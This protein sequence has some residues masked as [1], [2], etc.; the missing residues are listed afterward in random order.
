MIVIF[1]FHISLTMIGLWQG[2]IALE[3]LFY[4]QGIG[5]LFLRAVRFFDTPMVVATVVCFA[6]T[7]SQGIISWLRRKKTD[8]P[9][10]LGAHSTWEK[11]TLDEPGEISYSSTSRPKRESLWQRISPVFL[12]ILRNPPPR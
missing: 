6:Y 9:V 5:Q 2:A 11:K 1:T 3:V 10:S 4:W 12:M 8:A 7:R